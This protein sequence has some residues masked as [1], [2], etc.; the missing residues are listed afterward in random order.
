MVN[1]SRES[2]LCFKPMPARQAIMPT[3]SHRTCSCSQS[4]LNFKG[5]ECQNFRS[6]S[7]GQKD[8]RRHHRAFDAPS[9]PRSPERGCF[10]WVFCLANDSWKTDQIVS[11]KSKDKPLDIHAVVHP[12]YLRL[13]CFSI[14]VLCGYSMVGGRG[15]LTRAMYSSEML[16]R[17]RE[18]CTTW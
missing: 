9:N 17:T 7:L 2:S 6:R 1:R 14:S 16:T 12:R 10:G 18:S 11:R 5:A 4:F 15:T 13:L 8:L 3:Y